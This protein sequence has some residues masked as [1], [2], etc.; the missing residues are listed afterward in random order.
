MGMR[1]PCDTIPSKTLISYG[2]WLSISWWC[3]M[4]S[5][6]AAQLNV[7]ECV[8]DLEPPYLFPPENFTYTVNETDSATF[9]CV[10]VG[11]PAPSISI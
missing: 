4:H 5:I 11:I 9:V 3:N 10:V 2:V 7:E 8:S 6:I 1:L